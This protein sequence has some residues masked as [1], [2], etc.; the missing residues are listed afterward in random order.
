MARSRYRTMIGRTASHGTRD[1]EV[2][3]PVGVTRQTPIQLVVSH[4]FGGRRGKAW[5]VRAVDSAGN[6]L[7]EL[8][9]FGSSA[10]WDESQVG[11]KHTT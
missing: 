1:A 3:G 11:S 4:R 5:L 9:V 10:A 7:G 8:G 2:V 6:L